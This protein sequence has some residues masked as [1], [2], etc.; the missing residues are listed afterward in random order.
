MTVAGP[1]VDVGKLLGVI[2]TSLVATIGVATLF[3]LAILGIAR[4][5]DR[6]QSDRNGAWAYGV[7]AAMC[8]AGCAAATAYGVAL[9]AGK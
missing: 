5:S 9:L 4:S 7:L 3:S 2:A 6:R 8:V 1:V